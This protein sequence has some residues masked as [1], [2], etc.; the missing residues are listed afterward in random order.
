MLTG[1]REERAGLHDPPRKR[2]KEDR[3][4]TPPA[5]ASALTAWGPQAPLFWKKI[6]PKADR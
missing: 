4:D 3:G 5:L 2:G 1:G 6:Q